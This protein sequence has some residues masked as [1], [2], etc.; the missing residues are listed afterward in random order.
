MQTKFLIQAGYD[1]R[2]VRDLGSRVRSRPPSPPSAVELSTEFVGLLI[3]G[4]KDF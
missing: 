4:Y 1:P 2:V 3:S